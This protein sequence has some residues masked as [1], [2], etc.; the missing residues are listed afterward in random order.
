ME[1]HRFDG[2]PFSHQRSKSGFFQASVPLLLGALLLAP[3]VAVAQAQCGSGQQW[4]QFLDSGHPTVQVRCR[5]VRGSEAHNDWLVQFRNIGSTTANVEYILVH[6][7]TTK[8]PQPLSLDAHSV[9]T[10]RRAGMTGCLWG[11]DLFTTIRDQ[12]PDTLHN[13]APLLRRSP[14]T[15]S[16]SDSQAGGHPR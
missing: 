5:C 3:G 4:T 14:V 9:S 1:P 11:N 13:I 8:P 12:A 16:P 15:D 7:K 6:Y 2:R 10:A